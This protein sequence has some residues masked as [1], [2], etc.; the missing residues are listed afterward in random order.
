MS[1]HE[2]ALAC[3]WLG[4]E[5]ALTNHYSRA[6]G[7]PDVEKFL[8]LINN[9]HSDTGPVVKPVVLEPGEVWYYPPEEERD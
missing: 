9:L 4:V 2:A 5:Y 7:N 1:P 6:K 8:T 3:L